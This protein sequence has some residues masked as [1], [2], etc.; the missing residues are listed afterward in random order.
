MIWVWYPS[1]LKNIMRLSRF[2]NSVG[3]EIGFAFVPVLLK[4]YV[5][6]AI[7]GTSFKVRT[8]YERASVDLI[9]RNSIAKL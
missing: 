6:I 8:H 3:Y 4:C 7:Y 5:N 2:S 1:K 9:N